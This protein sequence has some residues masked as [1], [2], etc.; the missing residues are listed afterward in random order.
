MLCLIVTA[1]FYGAINTHSPWQTNHKGNIHYKLLLS[2]IKS[3]NA[4]QK[5]QAERAALR[6]QGAKGKGH[7]L[8]SLNSEQGTTATCCTDS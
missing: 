8:R 4:Q 5:Q 2:L 6:C 3:E 7:G 1:P